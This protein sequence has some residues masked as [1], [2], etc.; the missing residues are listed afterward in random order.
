MHLS[1]SLFFALL[2]ESEARRSFPIDRA[3][4]M[5][6]DKQRHDRDRDS[7]ESILLI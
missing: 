1:T 5:V 6:I 3:E 4:T 2:L 7:D